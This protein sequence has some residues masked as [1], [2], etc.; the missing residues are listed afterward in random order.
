M[1]CENQFAKGAKSK[2]IFTLS[3]HLT[4]VLDDYLKTLKIMAS[5]VFQSKAVKVIL[6]FVFLV[7]AIANLLTIYF[8]LYVSDTK[9]FVNYAS[10]FF[11]EFYVSISCVKQPRNIKFQPMLAILTVIFKGQ[12]VQHL[13]D[14]FKIWAIDSASKKL[15]SEIKLKIKIITAFVITNSL[16]AV[17]GGFLYVQPLSEDENLY[18][19][20][21][22]I[23]QYFPNQSSTLEFFYRMTYPILGYLMTV[24]AYQCLYYTQHINFQLRM[25]TEVVAE[26]APVKRF[27][28]FEHHLFYNK[29]YQTEIEQRLKFCIKRSQEFVQ[30]CVIKNSEIGSFIPEFAICGLLFGIGVTFFLSTGKFTSEYYLRMGVTSFGGVMTFS[31]LIWSGQTTETMTSELVKALN[32]VR[33]YNFNQSNK[34]LYLTLVMNIMKERKI[35][36]TENYSMNYRLGLAIVRNIYSVIS[37]VVSKRRH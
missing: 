26:F 15:Q 2:G 19:A 5:E 37:V 36:F 18:F 14:E 27:L 6:I 23:H 16:I 7:H 4:T 1:N 25:F 17:W 11:S 10:V 28:L 9:L 3:I 35:K 8:V 31:A 32:E 29:K 12:I 34:K 13:T 24:H 21:S 20:L 33:W 22:F 30:I